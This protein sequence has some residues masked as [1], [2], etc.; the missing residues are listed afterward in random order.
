MH[1]LGEEHFSID[2]AD[3]FAR[4]TDLNFMAQAIPELERIE[5][6]EPKHVVCRVRPA[7]AFLSGSL[8][9]TF[10]LVE[11]HPVE[12]V[13]YRVLGKGIGARV[14]VETEIKLSSEEI[15]TKLAWQSEIIER[16][17]LLKPVGQSLIKAA[18]NK[19]TTDA[20]VAFR[21]ALDSTDDD[22]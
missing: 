21:K 4:L 14:V 11:E 16:G 3:L 1:F 15:G 12:S 18:A 19:V 22:A 5:L 6:S 7:F 10:D 9:L 2:Q 13:K 20:W 8:T 17:G